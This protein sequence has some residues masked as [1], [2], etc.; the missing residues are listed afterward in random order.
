MSL[1]PQLRQ[2]LA[3]LAS[4]ATDGHLDAPGTARLEEILKSSEEAR[5]YYV[6][7]MGV[8]AALAW[9]GRAAM[10]E[11]PAASTSPRKNWRQ[12]WGQ[13]WAA[14]AILVLAMFGAW[15]MYPATPQAKTDGGLATLTNAVNIEW[16][17]AQ[18]P[19]HVANVL[20]P[21]WLRLK[22]GLAQVEFI[23]GTSV[24]IEGPASFRLDSAR[25]GYLESGRLIVQ[26]PHGS[27]GFRVDFPI[28]IVIDRGT[29]FALDVRPGLST[30]HV[31]EGL[32]S[33]TPTGGTEK[34]YVA[35]QA[36]AVD[37]LTILAADPRVFDYMGY[38]WAAGTFD[39]LSP[40]LGH[41]HHGPLSSWKGADPLESIRGQLGIDAVRWDK[42]K[43]VLGSYLEAQWEL[44]CLGFVPD[45][46]EF[47]HA[48]WDLYYSTQRSEVTDE[49][50]KQRLAN[51]R[52]TRQT[53]REQR[54]QTEHDLKDLLTL[55]EEAQ[56]VDMGYLR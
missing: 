17:Q 30:V 47:S 46:N 52:D 35:G 37:T 15:M 48:A 49:E 23:S 4:R 3:E 36:V 43:P 25:Q 50:L 27:G 41:P 10:A 9:A 44:K 32:V 29:A 19:R 7:F 33:V 21:G 31:L 39:Q 14:A 13:V 20:K 56:L 55:R 18:E 53:L 26:V 28:G 11:A 6:R 51:Y 34:S 16:D 8:S 42:I 54:D 45:T 1:A 5:V 22:S 24:W 40:G 2:E 38:G 12:T